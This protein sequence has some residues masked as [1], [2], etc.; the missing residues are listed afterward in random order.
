MEDPIVGGQCNAN[1]SEPTKQLKLKALMSY[2]N[3]FMVESNMSFTV[4]SS[5]AKLPLMAYMYISLEIFNVWTKFH[6]KK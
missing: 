2:H 1:L 4:Y 6:F 5:N 3:N